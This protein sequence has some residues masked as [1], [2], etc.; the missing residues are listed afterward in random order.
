MFTVWRLEVQDQSASM[1]G[2]W[3]KQR[4]EFSGDPCKGT[5]PIQEGSAFMTSL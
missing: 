4:S 5:N 1:T 3:W 2:F